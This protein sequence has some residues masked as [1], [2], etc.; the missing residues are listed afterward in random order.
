MKYVDRR[1]N[2]F[3]NRN[4]FLHALLGARSFATRLEAL[5]AH[6]SETI[7]PADDPTVLAMAG[8]IALRRACDAYVEAALEESPVETEP[9]AATV[10][11]VHGSLLR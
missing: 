3:A 5:S 11:N 9:P 1:P 10:E 7:L 2:D 4:T 8:V 6:E